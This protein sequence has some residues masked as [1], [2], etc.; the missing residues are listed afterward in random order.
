MS[1]CWECKKNEETDCMCIVECDTNCGAL[2]HPRTFE[3]Y[4]KAYEHWAN[5]RSLS[6]C[7]HGC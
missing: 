4:R 3:D 7:S 1:E 6:G 2:N 5:H